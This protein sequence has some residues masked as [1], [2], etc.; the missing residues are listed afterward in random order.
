[1]SDTTL[2]LGPIVFQGFELPPDIGF[3][4]AQQLAVHQLPGGGRIV[5][6][7]GPADADIQFAGILSGS[8]AATRA[9]ELDALRDAGLPL[10]LAW[11]VF[12]YLVVIENFEADYR[13]PWWIPYTVT[14]KVVQSATGLA[15]AAGVSLLGAAVADISTATGLAA[16][17]GIN[18]GGVGAAVGAAD[19][20]TLGTL[21]YTAAQSS[22]AGAQATLGSGISEAGSRIPTAAGTGLLGVSDPSAATTSL[23]SAAQGAGNLSAL[24]TARA[25][26]VRTSVNLANA[27]T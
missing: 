3:G 17:A 27:S 15:V 5:D 13:A 6:A 4:G 9:L 21:G 7:L 19:A 23:Q 26:V 11:D 22:L 14:C 25:Y 10:P 16:P 12:F 18:L 8:D 20:A 2:V 1:M 24:V